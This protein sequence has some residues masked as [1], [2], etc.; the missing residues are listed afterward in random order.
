LPV[1]KKYHHAISSF[2]ELSLEMNLVV[3]DRR[4]FSELE[5]KSQ[6]SKPMMLMLVGISDG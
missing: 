1:P 4:I 3:K 2:L 6:T 5:E